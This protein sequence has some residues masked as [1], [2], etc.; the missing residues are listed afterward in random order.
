MGSS[1]GA[2]FPT[3]FRSAPRKRVDGPVSFTPMYRT[4]DTK[5]WTDLK[6][7]ALPSE[8]KLLML[9]LITNPLTHVSGL[10]RLPLVLLIHE[11]SVPHDRAVQVLTA[12]ETAGLCRYDYENEV[13]WVVNML[14]Y[15]GRGKQIRK[16][17]ENH[18]PSLHDS[19]LVEQFLTHYHDWGIVYR[20]KGVRIPQSSNPS[21]VPD[22]VP[23]RKGVQGETNGFDVFWSVYPR[24]EAK[25]KAREAWERIKLPPTLPVLLQAVAEQKTWPQWMKDGGTFIP[26]PTTWLNGRRWEDVRPTAPGDWHKSEAVRKLEAKIDGR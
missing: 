11:T 26:H 10:Y 3:G 16:A 14:R 22:P 19:P 13:V 7:R 6:I 24:K 21:P 12:I 15:Q 9:Y 5:F 2:K 17:V 23:V 1:F 4:I 20:M 25:Q 18:L 8:Q